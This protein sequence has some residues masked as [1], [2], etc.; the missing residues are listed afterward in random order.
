MFIITG[1]PRSRT[2]WFAAFMTALGAPCLHEASVLV[3]SKEEFLGLLENYGVADTG[4]VFNPALKEL[5][6]PTVIIERDSLEVLCSL[7]ELFPGQANLLKAYVEVHEHKLKKLDGLRIKFNEINEKAKEV[8]KYC[9]GSEP[10][11]DL[12]VEQYTNL[13]IEATNL[14]RFTKV[15]KW[16]TFTN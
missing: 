8:F 14:E 5:E 12:M 9:T 10:D 13:N 7:Q 4:I 15:P 6:L 1:L 3:D 11:N 2:A 16:L